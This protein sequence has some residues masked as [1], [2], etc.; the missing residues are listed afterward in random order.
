MDDSC[1]NVTALACGVC[2]R[3]A[4]GGERHLAFQND[5]RGFRWMRVIG[6]RCVWAVLPDVSVKKSFVVQLPLEGREVHA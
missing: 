5:V 6:I 4:G 3:L 2:A 1:G